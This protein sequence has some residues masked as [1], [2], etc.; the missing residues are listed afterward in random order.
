MVAAAPAI[1]P[2]VAPA[3]SPTNAGAAAPAVTR[4]KK[5]TTKTLIAF[6]TCLLN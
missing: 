6:F 1:A 5:V 2:N 3:D 4:T